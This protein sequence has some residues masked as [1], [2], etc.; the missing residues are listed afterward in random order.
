MVRY[1]ELRTSAFDLKVDGLE[2]LHGKYWSLTFPRQWI[3]PM[4]DVQRGAGESWRKSLA[5]ASL[6][7]AMRAVVP[8]VASVGRSVGHTANPGGWLYASTPVESAGLRVILHAWL[9][10]IAGAGQEEYASNVWNSLDP[11]LLTWQLLRSDELGWPSSVDASPDTREAT[12][13]LKVLPQKTFDLVP[14][15]LIAELLQSSDRPDGFERRFHRCPS[16][17]GKGVELM[18][19]PPLPYDDKYGGAWPY[20][21]RV[22]ITAQ[23]SPFQPVPVVHVSVGVRRWAPRAPRIPGGQSV[24]AYL[25]SSVPWIDQLAAS[26]SFRIAPMRWKRGPEGWALSWHEELAYL[27]DQVAFN[28]NLIR[29]AELG[30]DPL[31]FHNEP[32]HAAA[33]VHASTGGNRHRVGAGASARDRHRIVMWI[34]QS[35]EKFVTPMPSHPRASVIVP[36]RPTA[37][38][39]TVRRRIAEATGERL[40]TVEIHY[41][42]SDVRE[43]L[44]DAV[45]RDLGLP[46]Q[47]GSVDVCRWSTPELDV[48]LTA[49][50]IGA[51]G[52]P[53]SPPTDVRNRM[54]RARRATEPRVE[55]VNETLGRADSTTV[56]FVEL[57]G[58][59]SF[60]EP[61]T[62]PKAA[63][64][65][66]FAQTG[67]HV[68]F[69][70]PQQATPAAAADRQPS[71]RHRAAASWLDLRRQIVGFVQPPSLP[72]RGVALPDRLDTVA[73][74]MLRRNATRGNA[75]G[76]HQLPIAVWISTDEETIHARTP[77][78]RWRPYHQ[79]LLD[80]AC[81]RPFQLPDSGAELTEAFVR[82]VLR[83]VHAD[84]PVLLL[85][86][87]Q[88]LRSDWRN[89]ANLNVVV[90]ALGVGSDE[91][92]RNFPHLR[93]VLVRTHDSEE[94][95]DCYGQADQQSGLPSGLFRHPRS[96]RIFASVAPKPASAATHGSPMGSRVEGR[97]N[98]AGRDVVETG[99]DAFNPQYV[100]LTVARMAPD[101]DPVTWAAIAHSQRWLAETYKG[102]LI[103]PLPLHLAR[104][105]M[106]YAIPDLNTDPLAT[107]D[108]DSTEDVDPTAEE[109]AE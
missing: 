21:Y 37:G 80:L 105:A 84:R 71:L 34:A 50:P 18:S 55:Q 6:N 61:L 83:D 19:W 40:L 26:R 91:L 98:A 32:E 43:A 65:V 1:D 15:I 60:P 97:T 54:L 58:P 12:Q 22:R 52:S 74:F 23:T 62:D 95:P 90:D 46:P 13:A 30:K 68:Q 39:A 109:D 2:Q 57:R 79:A 77:G 38:S 64:R 42:T 92:A 9:K 94:T 104:K 36:D 10:H 67:R 103:L 33:I 99:K 73:I 107:E 56:A 48:V 89:L 93:H 35:L 41:D 88:N 51:I 3:A 66:G 96:H 72:V 85:T 69:L 81:D 49:R 44:R 11:Q 100:E 87:S 102:T 82:D 27:F 4:L 20:S 28:R 24:N 63:L 5:I 7:R 101:D 47:E 86:W 75:Y 59:E 8:D 106:E 76:R 108:A 29:P 25:L 53:L 17:D 45:T 78:K 14:E 31:R 70:T 16:P